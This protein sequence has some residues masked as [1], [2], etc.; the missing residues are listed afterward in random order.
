MSSNIIGPLP[1]KSNASSE[2]VKQESGSLDDIK[3]PLVNTIHTTYKKGK[4]KQNVV[5][6]ANTSPI[7]EKKTD[8]VDKTEK[9]QT[10]KVKSLPPQKNL[11]HSSQYKYQGLIK[12]LIYLIKVPRK[13]H[14]KNRI[15]QG[16]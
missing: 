13:N 2:K 15:S 1:K 11:T 3:N 14:L 10:S 9:S 7:S 6:E 5:E 4:T 8:S 16:Q 12:E